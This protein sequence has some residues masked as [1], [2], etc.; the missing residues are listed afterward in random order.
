VACCIIVVDDGSVVRVR[1]HLV[2]EGNEYATGMQS[3]K[4][5]RKFT[6]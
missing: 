2:Y 6:T 5:G 4:V 3:A 1:H